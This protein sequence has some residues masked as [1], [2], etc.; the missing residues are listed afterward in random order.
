MIRRL[1][2]SRLR[3]ILIAFYRPRRLAGVPNWLNR[4]LVRTSRAK[5]TGD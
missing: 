2:R 1:D 3:N 5:A 4:W